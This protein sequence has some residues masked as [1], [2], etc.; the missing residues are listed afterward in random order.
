MRKKLLEG[1]ILVE[2]D[3][4]LRFTQDYLFSSPSGAAAAVL[5]RTANGW[6][7]WKDKDGKTLSEI[8]RVGEN[9]QS[10]SVE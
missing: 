2:Q 5:G 10:S 1:E 9:E 6:I 4:N 3:G 8:K 7:E